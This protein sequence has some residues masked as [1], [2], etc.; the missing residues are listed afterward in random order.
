VP[1][2]VTVGTDSG[3]IPPAAAEPPAPIRVELLDIPLMLD[4]HDASAASFYVA[5]WPLGPGRFR[6]A[7]LFEPTADGLDYTTAAI[8]P[9]A[10]VIGE[11]LW[12]LYPGPTGRWDRGNVF[13]VQ[14][15]HG[16]LQSLPEA[17]VLAGANAALVGRKVLQFRTAELVAEGHYRLSNLLRGQL[18]TEH[19]TGL[20]VDWL[21]APV[22]Q[23]PTGDL[24]QTISFTNTGVGLRRTRRCI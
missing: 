17:R 15:D 14:L 12:D 22:P 2:F 10:S 23:G 24:A 20:G 9:V 4:S 3:V 18:G 19:A 21:A 1:E 7:A 6:G 13:E 16:E 11:T 5:A 8:A